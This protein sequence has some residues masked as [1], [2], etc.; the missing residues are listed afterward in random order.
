[1][2]P[3][4]HLLGKPETTNPKGPW[5]TEDWLL[6]RHLVKVMCEDGGKCGSGQ[7]SGEQNHLQFNMEPQN[8][9][10]FEMFFPFPS[11]FFSKEAFSGSSR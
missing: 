3:T 9:V 11:I 8:W 6:L 5:E 4:T 7:K 1:M 10:N 2:R